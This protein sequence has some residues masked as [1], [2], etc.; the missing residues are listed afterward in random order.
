MAYLSVDVIS[1]TSFTF[2][3]SIITSANK[4]LKWWAGNWNLMSF[5]IISSGE[6]CRE[7]YKCAAWWEIKFALTEESSECKKRASS[8]CWWHT[9]ASVLF[10]QRETKNF[11]PFFR[12]AL[13]I[14]FTLFSS[15][16][17]PLH[18]HLSIILQIPLHILELSK[19][20]LFIYFFISFFFSFEWALSWINTF[21]LFLHFFLP[22]HISHLIL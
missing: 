18:H 13:K 6:S 19:K 14:F 11:I 1:S 16:T 17:D 22:P 5:K 3:I 2:F 10:S 7:G 15:F 12:N 20:R 8:S 9:H 4:N 21:D